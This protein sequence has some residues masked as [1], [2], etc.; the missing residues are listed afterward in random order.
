MG[1]KA[2]SR[3]QFIGASAEAALLGALAATLKPLS[4][5]ALDEGAIST[6]FDPRFPAARTRALELA[7]AGRLCPTGG[8]PTALVLQALQGRPAAARR[9]QGVTTESVP[10]CLRQLAPHAQLTQRRLDRDLFEWRFEARS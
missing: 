10:F 4:A 3:R 6:L 1:S 9:L 5:F 8:D 7:G 2:L